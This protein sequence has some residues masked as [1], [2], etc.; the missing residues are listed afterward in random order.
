MQNEIVQAAAQP[1]W[2]DGGTTG[3]L[4]IHGF[5]GLP[6]EMRPLGAFLAARSYTV[7]GTL[8]ARHGRHPD[9]MY[10]VRWSE[11]TASVEETFAELQRR[12]ERVFVIGYSLGGLLAL[13]LASNHQT[14]GVITLAAALQLNGG[15]PLRL[16]PVARYAVPWFYPMRAA[17]FRDPRLRE[18][19]SSKIGAIDFDDPAVI[20]QLRGSIRIPTGAIYELVRLSQ[21]VRRELPRITAPALVLQGRRDDTVLPIS[22]EQIVA[23]LG[24]SDKQVA[25]FERSG[26]LLPNDVE[27]RAV[28]ATIAEW[29]E[30]RK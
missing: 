1:F 2:I 7:A 10:N 14:A 19:L 30:R 23:G 5:G 6:G 9:E 16:L 8:L 26:H 4:L 3:L 25:W 17:D 18:D 13:H 28:Q 12:C 11:W 24:S 21:L 15:W 22:A 29:L 27:Q 20:K